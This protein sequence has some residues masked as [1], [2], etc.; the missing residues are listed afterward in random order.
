MTTN[1]SAFPALIQRFPIDEEWVVQDG[2]AIPAWTLKADGC[3]VVFATYPKD[4]TLTSH[5]HDDLDIAGV[6]TKG[7]V[8]LTIAGEQRHYGP[9]DWFH[10]PM[11]VEH[12]ATYQEETSQVEVI[13][14]RERERE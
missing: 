2:H 11:S 8:R 10:V 14:R 9:G 5:R 1:E 6:V 7:L 3:D 12:S 13:F 4:L